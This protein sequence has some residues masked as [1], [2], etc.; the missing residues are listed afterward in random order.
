MAT[1]PFI[2]QL[3]NIPTCSEMRSRVAAYIQSHPELS[4]AMVA[5]KLHRHRSTIARIARDFH[6]SHDRRLAAEDLQKPVQGLD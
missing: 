3:R 1:N 4:F 6:V 2:P 5:S